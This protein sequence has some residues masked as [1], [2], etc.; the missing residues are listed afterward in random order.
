MQGTYEK[1]LPLPNSD[2]EAFWKACGRHEL[3]FRKCGACAFI[4]WPPSTYCPRCYSKEMEWIT[5]SGKGKIYTFAVYH[6]VFHPAF[7]DDVP[8]VVALVELEEG[9]FFLSNIVGCKPDE[10]SC[11]MPVEVIW[12]DVTEDFTLP[13]F[14]KVS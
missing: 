14:R 8:Y 11:G 12:E 9:P 13:K 6:R 7:K 2:T 10:V 3:R 4:R 1:P 5:A